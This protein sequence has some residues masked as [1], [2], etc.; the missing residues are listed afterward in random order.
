MAKIMV[1]KP[2]VSSKAVES[3][4]EEVKVTEKQKEM[5][6]KNPDY[7]YKDEI[8]KKVLD[9]NE[10]TKLV[11][12]VRRSNTDEF[13]L[14]WVDMRLY[15]T[16]PNYTGYTKQGFCFPLERLEEVMETLQAV[17]EECLA[18]GL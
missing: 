7:Y 14:P 9:L 11:F 3:I 17:D 1:K 12:S 4:K 6:K 10:N 13:G 8:P 16:T 2:K 15:V 18:K 5:C